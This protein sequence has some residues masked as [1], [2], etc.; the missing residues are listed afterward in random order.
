[1]SQTKIEDL[2]D[3]LLDAITIEGSFSQCK[4]FCFKILA[5]YSHGYLSVSDKGNEIILLE[6]LYRICCEAEAL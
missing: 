6:D 4:N 5:A 3:Q 2:K 1:M